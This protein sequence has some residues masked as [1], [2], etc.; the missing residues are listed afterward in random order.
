M[1]KF[2]CLFILLF[3]SFFIYSNELIGK[4]YYDYFPS[5]EFLDNE[6]KL[7][8][9]EFEYPNDNYDGTFKYNIV[10]KGYFTFLE[11]FF[12]NKKELWLALYSKDYLLVYNNKYLEPILIG[13]LEINHPS[14]PFYFPK[15]IKS[16][17]YLTEGKNK[18][19]PDNMNNCEIEKV[20]VEGIK[21]Y[22]I[23]EKIYLLKSDFRTLIILNGY[24]SF[25]KPYL[26]EQ[27][28]RVKKLKIIDKINKKEFIVGLKD[29][30]NPQ[31]ILSGELL[32]REL[33]LEILEVYKGNKYEDTCI[34]LI[35]E[36]YL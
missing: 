12:K 24:I 6:I 30:P 11:I 5:I 16:S 28:S 17:S 29:T 35:I 27:N 9:F 2:M 10:K 14:S 13:C 15:N 20:W 7:E 25:N 32:E 21:G 1:K 22:G 18:Y 31:K 19:L 26:Y 33:I 4:K 36:S 34:S 3:I 8:G 23:G